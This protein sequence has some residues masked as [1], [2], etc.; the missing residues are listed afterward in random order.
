MNAAAR[1]ATAGWGAGRPRSSSAPSPVVR[2]VVLVL[3][4][5]VVLAAGA[6]APA[7]AVVLVA[8]VPAVAGAGP[9]ACR[10]WARHRG[11][12]LPLPADLALAARVRTLLLAEAT[13]TSGRLRVAVAEPVRAGDE[14]TLRWFAGAL[15]HAAGNE[16][17]DEVGDALARGAARGR[18]AGVVS[19]PG[20]GIA[21]SVDRHPVRVGTP[22]WIG[23]PERPPLPGTTVAVEVDGRLL[24][25]IGL[26]AE[27]RPEAAPALVRLTAL[28]VDPVLVSVGPREEAARIADELGGLPWQAP[29]EPAAVAG[30]GPVAHATPLTGLPGTLALTTD[31][32]DLA[33]SAL[34][35]AHRTR[36]RALLTD[37]AALG[38]TGA[39]AAL[40]LVT[41]I[42]GG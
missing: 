10:W 19:H 33:V 35:L 30:A 17:G 8:G 27:V 15:A 41:T 21:G 2:A 18:L 9:A 12:G 11:R 29:P 4:C 32:V 22:A 25:R 23:A 42:M 20:A 14:R 6:S 3:V 40:A 38:L 5:A 36:A 13:V 28:G 7:V 34:E 1:R 37:R 24:G 16:I 31:R 39:V 26:V